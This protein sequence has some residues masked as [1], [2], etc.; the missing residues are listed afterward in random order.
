MSE[1]AKIIFLKFMDCH[2]FVFEELTNR[3]GDFRVNLSKESIIAG[4]LIVVLLYLSKTHH[5]F[6]MLV[7]RLHLVLD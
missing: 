6:H 2:V 7:L 4:L 3:H 1:V 5:P